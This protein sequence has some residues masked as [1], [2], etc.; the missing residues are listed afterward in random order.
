LGWIYVVIGFT[1]HTKNEQKKIPHTLALAN[2]GG[3]PK[4]GGI[5]DKKKGAE[6]PF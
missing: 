4:L 1:G 2:L 3:L 5:W 6:A